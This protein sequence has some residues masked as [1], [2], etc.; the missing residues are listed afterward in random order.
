MLNKCTRLQVKQV[1][2]YTS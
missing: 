2:T 1:Y